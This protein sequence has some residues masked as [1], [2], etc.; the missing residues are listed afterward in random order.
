VASGLRQRVATGLLLAGLVIVIL[1]W[2]PPSVAVAAVMVVVAAGAWEWAGFAGITA[3]ARR[4]GYM[5]AVLLGIALAWFAT[6]GLPNQLLLLAASAAWWVAAL[7]WLV[8]AP[9]TGGPR[10]AAAAGFAVLVPAAIGL[11]RLV[12]LEPRGQE[13]LL[14]L[15]VLIAAADIGAYA[16][17]RLLGSRKLAPR[18][19][20][21]KTWEGFWSGVLAAGVAAMG[22]GLLLGEPLWPWT[23]MCVAVALSSVVG[24]LVESMFKRQVGLKDS[25]SL[26]PGHGG[27]LDRLDSLAAAGPMFLLGLLLLGVH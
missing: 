16:G 11:G 25:S 6:A 19:S 7:A 8:L 2:L 22:G 20:P 10:V 14:F 23:A 12:A 21:N 5:A 9:A 4:G 13:L 1:L 24:D 3:P 18:V 27:V 15:L 17:G 26:L